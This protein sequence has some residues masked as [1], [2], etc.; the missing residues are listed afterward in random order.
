MSTHEARTH[1]YARRNI[2]SA[3]VYDRHA[4]SMLLANVH[5]M[6]LV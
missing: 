2:D 1:A 3:G 6:A 4:C 5:P